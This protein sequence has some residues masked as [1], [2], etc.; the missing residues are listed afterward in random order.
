MTLSDEEEVRPL[1][2]EEVQPDRPT[3]HRVNVSALVAALCLG[4]ATL[5]WKNTVPC[6]PGSPGLLQAKFAR[7][8]DAQMALKVEGLRSVTNRSLADGIVMHAMKSAGKDYA[9]H[10]EAHQ[11]RQLPE[12]PVDA[13]RSMISVDEIRTYRAAKKAKR[14]REA[15]KAFCA[16]NV[17]EA[18]ISIM[19]M[20]DDINAIIRTCPPP[21]D[22]ESE[23]ACQVDGAILVAWVGNLAAKL[24]FAAS[25]CAITTN[26]NALCSVG[27]TGLVSAMGE[28]AATAS[29]AA[30][31]CVPTPPSLTTT[32]ISV[33]GDQTVRGLPGRRLLIGEGAIGNGVQ[34][35]I[36]VGM[37]VTNIAN[38]G[39][40]ING[41]VNSG[42]CGWK[43]KAS[44][45]NKLTG[46]PEALCTVDIGGAVTYI[47]QV[48]TFI[49]LIVVHCND[50]L[51]ISA[52]CG[53][54]V[55][56][57]TTAAAAISPYGA[58]VHAACRENHIA[59]SPQL[60]AKI[61][62][63]YDVPDVPRR[64]TELKDA[65]ANVREIRGRL[66]EEL[67]F[68]A[69]SA[70]GDSFSEANMEMLLHLMEGE[71]AQEKASKG[72][73]PFSQCEA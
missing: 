52:L 60:Q 64:L 3:G 33:L 72:L 54:S 56:G 38:M 70:R 19:G 36:D 25:N 49:N 57:I 14:A 5:I 73:W 17:L 35:G 51:D 9:K 67:G 63:L 1:R 68:N 24:S 31:T 6:K 46:I 12:S 41:A 50:F 4:A 32:K 44:P 27:V 43:A 55:A 22:G 26:V 66:E 30:A 59:K 2:L 69:S 62:G 16:F 42:M 23:L 7:D 58:A 48:V 15:K 53:A 65:M 8:V 45:L 21:R 18:F 39:L 10:Y 11:V 71:S 61:N 29:L 28:L 40:A 34:C 13:A 47:S 37:V 20:G